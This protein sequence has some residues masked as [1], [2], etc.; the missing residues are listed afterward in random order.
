M[1]GTFG[2]R[3]LDLA[4]LFLA[5]YAFAFV[6]LG[7]KTGLEH[8]KAIIHTDAARAAG[9][10]VLDAVDRLR[11]RLLDDDHEEPIAPRGKAGAPKLP[12]HRAE[13]PE[14]AM[15]VLVHDGPDA[16]Q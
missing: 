11:H 7:R 8:A 2:K 1:L 6:P 15:V 3:A 12:K 16:S 4:V 5:L 14:N 10:D 13:A 9:R